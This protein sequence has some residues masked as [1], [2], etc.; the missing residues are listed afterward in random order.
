MHCSEVTQNDCVAAAPSRE[1]WIAPEEV[2]LPESGPRN[3][4]SDL[5]HPA[6]E[7]VGRVEVGMGEKVVRPALRRRK[8][9][10]AAS[11]ANRGKSAERDFGFDTT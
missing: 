3:G 2:Q 5:C 9:K 1:T 7:P 6:G 4:T 11:R 8:P 10:T